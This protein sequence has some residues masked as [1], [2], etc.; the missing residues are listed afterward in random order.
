VAANDIGAIDFLADL[1]LTD[2]FGLASQA[3]MR[4]KLS[5]EWRS[6]LAGTL[7]R[8]A[9]AEGTRVAVLYD[10]WFDYNPATGRAAVPPQWVRV[11]AWT[12]P[13]NVVCGGA[14]VTW[15][16]VIP[17]EAEALRSGLEEF[18]PSHPAG[19]TVRYYPLP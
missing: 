12:I 10:T 17:E 16:A 9:S 14:T 4:A 7:D 8:L 15:Y 11:A 3:V 18:S 1:N 5:G 13:Q 6:D 2:L 19:V